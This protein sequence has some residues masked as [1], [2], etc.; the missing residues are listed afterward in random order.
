VKTI[1]LNLA[2]H[3][4]RDYRPVYAVIVGASLLIVL[5]GFYNVDTYLRYRNATKTT[6]ALITQLDSQASEEQQRAQHATERLRSINLAMLRKQS[7]F[8]NTQIAERAFS[9]SELLDRLERVLPDDVHILSIAPSFD[10]TGSVHLALE[11]EAKNGNGMVATID[12]M[13]ADSHFHNAFPSSEENT[14]TGFHF[15][16]S[17]EYRPSI[18][19]AIQ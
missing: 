12:R 9:W 8:I 13:N 17:T 3:P 19:R 7:E 14:G 15:G 6:R 5:L 18:T 2:S 4:Y 11:C 10:K 16:L 1:H